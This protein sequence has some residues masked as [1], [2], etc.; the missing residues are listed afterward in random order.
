MA[1]LMSDL[2]F[3]SVSF[4]LDKEL[5]RFESYRPCNRTIADEEFLM[6]RESTASTHILAMVSPLLTLTLVAPIFCLPCTFTEGANATNLCTYWDLFYFSNTK[7]KES[8]SKPFRSKEENTWCLLLARIRQSCRHHIKRKWG[9]DGGGFNI[10]WCW[11]GVNL[12]WLSVV[13]SR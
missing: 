12:T 7:A 5:Q 8:N 4:I 1:E 13:S 6:V 11:N 9:R 10:R 3:L 2:T